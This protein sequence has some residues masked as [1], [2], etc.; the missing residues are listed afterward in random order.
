MTIS[1]AKLVMHMGPTYLQAMGTWKRASRRE[2]KSKKKSKKKE[3]EV[4]LFEF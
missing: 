4:Q 3:A 2:K 1:W